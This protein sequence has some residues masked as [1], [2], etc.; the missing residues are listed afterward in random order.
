MSE[1]HHTDATVECREATGLT[2]QA[3][4]DHPPVGRWPGIARSCSSA[5]ACRHPPKG[6]RCCR[7]I[8]HRPSSCALTRFRG[9]DG[10]LKVDHRLPNSPEGRAL[11]AS[12]RSGATTG[13]SGRVSRARRSA[14]VRGCVRFVNRWSRRSPRCRPAPTLKRPPK[15]ARKETIAG[16]SRGSDGARDRARA[17][18]PSRRDARRWQLHRP[19]SR[20]LLRGGDRPC[21]RG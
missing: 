15:C 6:S 1:H 19:D 2:R 4:W 12:V 21:P 11:A 14:G 16:C 10:T 8:G 9:D 13:L 20:G 5:P 17:A 18:R 7:N 3:D